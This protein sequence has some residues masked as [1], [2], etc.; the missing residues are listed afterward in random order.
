MTPGFGL[1]S[2]PL[3]PPIRH[4]E[5]LRPHLILFPFLSLVTNAIFRRS[6]SSD[7]AFRIPR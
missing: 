4:L 1:M 5:V 6:N 3:Q 7:T 2:A